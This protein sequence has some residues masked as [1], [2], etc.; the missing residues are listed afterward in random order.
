MSA[1]TQSRPDIH[2]EFVDYLERSGRAMHAAEQ[3]ATKVANDRV[4]IAQQV[5]GL[6][7]GLLDRGLIQQGD[8]KQASEMLGSHNSTLRI[9][10]NLLSQLDEARREQSVKQAAAGPGQAVAGRPAATKRAGDANSG[11]SGGYLDRRLG[12]GETS[13]A[14]MALINSL[15]LADRLGR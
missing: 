2:T 15:G 6:V 14:D 10:G 7:Q 11:R 12:A 3:L 1:Q 13:E 9:V 5:P 4:K 8:V